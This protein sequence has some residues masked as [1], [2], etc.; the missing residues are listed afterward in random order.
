MYKLQSII[1]SYAYNHLFVPINAIRSET[2][3]DSN[4]VIPALAALCRNARRDLGAKVLCALRGI[5]A[6]RLSLPLAARF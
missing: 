5:E 1:I 4:E 3:A 6:E 2:D